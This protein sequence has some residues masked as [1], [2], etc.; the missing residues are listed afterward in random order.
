MSKDVK[1]EK[2]DKYEYLD[3]PEALPEGIDSD[4][5][6]IA[7]YYVSLPFGL[8][9]IKISQMAAIE[10]STGTWVP[11][12]GET[13]EV[14]RRHVARVIAIH[15]APQYEWHVPSDVKW[16]QYIIQVAFPIINLCGFQIPMLLSTVA[17]NILSGG[18]VKLLDL[19]FPKSYLKGFKGPKFG[20][21]GVRKHLGVKERPLLNNM[22][23]PCTGYPPE[24]GARL[25]YE[26]AL[27]G[28]DIVKDDE[29]LANADFNKVEDRVVKYMEL[30]D[31][32]YE[33]TGEK[34]MYTPNVTDT[35]QK[36][37][38]LAEKVIELGGN[39]LMI[40]YLTAGFETMR[41]LAEDP[42]INVPILAHMDFSGALYEDPYSGLSSTLVLAKLPRLTGADILVYP[43]PYGKAP[44]LKERYIMIGKM[45]RYPFQHIKPTF[46][47]PSGGIIPNIVPKIVEDFRNDVV[48]AAGGAIHAHPMGPVAGGKA[49][50]Q[51]IE[52]A[53]KGIPL[54]E[55]AKEHEELRVALEA[56]RSS[57]LLP[58]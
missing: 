17:G 22:I 32:A 14:R 45:L 25:F 41:A 40:N 30:A 51:A 58:I 49:F 23:K 26:A 47:M 18:K 1:V 54:K 28:V 29:L 57:K 52:A 11:V 42:S 31:K 7:T 46:P 27:G 21:E 39:G 15:E 2:K 13:P 5:F 10:Q 48:I 8:D 4:E 37:L 55:Y 35:P 38:E 36:T 3:T 24:V 9:V 53:M 33:E 50:R 6:I 34:T 44:F 20:I 43:A 16:R 56:W 12:P 19:W